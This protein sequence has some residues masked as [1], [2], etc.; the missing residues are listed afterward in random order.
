MKA[1]I[2]I[3]LLLLSGAAYALTVNPLGTTAA[4]ISVSNSA[5]KVLAGSTSRKSWS[6]YSETVNIR[7]NFGGNNDSAP[8]VT[9]TTTRGF[10]MATGIV[11]TVGPGPNSNV[12]A[13]N[14]PQQRVDC[15]STG[16]ATNVDI[17]TSP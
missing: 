4:P 16:A 17:I 8:T 7:C 13:S 14:D 6:L 9:P 1:K 10:L 15:I 2:A 3:A 5:V 12:P 11:Y